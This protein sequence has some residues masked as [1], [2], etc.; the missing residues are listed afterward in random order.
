M[1]YTAREYKAAH[2]RV[3]SIFKWYRKD[4]PHG[5]IC[6]FVRRFYDRGELTPPMKVK[7]L[8]YDWSKNDLPTS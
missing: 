8:K 1:E 5:D 4:L 6:A 2:L 7:Y 3:S